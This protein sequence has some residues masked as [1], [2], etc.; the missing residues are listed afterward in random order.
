MSGY[1][2]TP[3]LVAAGW[4]G[5]RVP[6]LVPAQVA[7]SLPPDPTT[8]TLF[9]TKAT[10]GRG[11]ITVNAIPGSRPS[12]HVPIRKTVVRV[13]SWGV[14]YQSNKPAWLVAA[15]NAEAIRNA[16]EVRSALYS[17]PLT[18]ALAGY[19]QAVVLSVYLIDEPR[20]IAN[21][22]SGYARFAMNLEVDWALG[23]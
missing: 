4:L 20:R 22:P 16:T 14:F 6:E 9:G 7:G 23:P 11:F 17:T 8:W 21:D 19:R 18:L 1:Y 10:N 3:E 12:V 15:Q 13:D 5:Q 2:P